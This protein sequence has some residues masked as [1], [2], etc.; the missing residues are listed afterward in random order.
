MHDDRAAVEVGTIFIECGVYPKI[1]GVLTARLPKRSPWVARP[2]IRWAMLRAPTRDDELQE[3]LTTMGEETWYRGEGIGVTPSGPGKNLHDLG[4]GLYLIDKEEVALQYAKTRAPGDQSWQVLEVTVER[5]SLGN[6]L[7]L[8][9][10]P[11]WQKF[12]T[13]PM[14]PG[15]NNPHLNKSRLDHLRI[16]YEL[17]G[18]FFDEFKLANKID[19][20]TYD[21][22]V[23]PEY[24]RGGKQLCILHK[25]GLP[26]RLSIR[27]RSLF[28]PR[29]A[30]FTVKPPSNWPR[31]IGGFLITVGIRPF[32]RLHS[33]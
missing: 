26:G 14:F 20:K 9:M 33:E 4:D 30:N 24:V 21:A 7:D 19:I 25:N 5:Q 31:V 11:R 18:Q 22:V 8:T 6:V 2:D 27:I 15:T 16:K 32:N 17:Y 12:M 29:M 28:R 23:G 1:L 3:R 13:E 10:D